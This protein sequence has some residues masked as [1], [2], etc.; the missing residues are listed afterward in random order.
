MKKTLT[1][2]L[3]MIALL[4]GLTA[5]GQSQAAP[6]STEEKSASLEELYNSYISLPWI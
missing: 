5:C 3:L 2:L 4:S 1:A 6:Q